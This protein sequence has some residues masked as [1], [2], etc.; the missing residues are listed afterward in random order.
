MLSNFNV[1]CK[2]T[3]LNGIG[4]LLSQTT[5]V[6][7]GANYVLGNGGIVSCVGSSMVAFLA[8][9]FKVP[10]I[11]WCET[12]K[13]TERVNLDQI[14]NNQMGDPREI[15]NNYLLPFNQEFKD[16]MLHQKNLDVRYLKYDF[17]PMSCVNMILCE[18]GRIS[19][20]SVPVIVKEFKEDEKT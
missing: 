5:K 13:F 16:K 12:Y 4:C 18:V 7:I 2:Y 15:I 20:V 17:T 1:K 19:P 8:S 14:K 11:V 3:L 10:V 6:F 9:Q